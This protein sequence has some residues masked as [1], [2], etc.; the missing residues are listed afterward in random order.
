[1]NRN[2]L[3]WDPTTITKLRLKIND[4]LTDKSLTNDMRILSRPMIGK[5]FTNRRLVQ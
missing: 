1:M 4:F 3:H 5:K 2:V